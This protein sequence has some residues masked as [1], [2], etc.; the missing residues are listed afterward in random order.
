MGKPIP[1]IHDT[2]RGAQDVDFLLQK[3]IL[4]TKQGNLFCIRA[5]IFLSVK[6]IKNAVFLL[7]Q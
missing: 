5:W 1:V 6:D 4:L 3:R 2:G 7:I